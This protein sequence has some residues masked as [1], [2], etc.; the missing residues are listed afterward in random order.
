[1]TRAI[2][3]RHGVKVHGFANAGNHLHL[4]VAFPRP[5]AYAPYIRALTGGLAIAVLGTGRRGGRWKGR[6]A[7]VKHA[8]HKERPRFWDHRPFTRIA[9]WGRDFAGLKNYLALNR[10]ESRGF[11]KS[12]GRQGLA[13]ID[14]LVAAGKLPREGARQLLATGFCLS[15]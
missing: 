15:G 7:Q 14:G 5:A 1:M 4:I 6:D 10:L 3:T 8:A 2:A 12:I 13:L 11:A 9:S